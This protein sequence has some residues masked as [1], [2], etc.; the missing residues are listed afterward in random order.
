VP[1]SAPE[2]A[3]EPAAEPASDEPAAT[4]SAVTPEE[5]ESEA[6]YSARLAKAMADLRKKDLALRE[7][8]QGVAS[9]R[10][11]RDAIQAELAQIKE[12]LKDPFKALK[13]AGTTYEDLTRKYLKKE[14]VPPDDRDEIR[15]HVDE[16]ASALEQK[17]AEMQ[18]KLDAAEAERAERE[19]VVKQQQ[20]REQHLE[21]VSTVISSSADKFPL[22]AALKDGPQRLLNVCYANEANDPMQ[23]A[24][25][26]EKAIR[27]DL[28]ALMSAP[29]ALAALT[30]GQPKLREQLLAALGASQESSRRTAQPDEGPRALASDMVSAPS[31]P[32]TRPLKRS[33]AEKKQ[34][35]M[36]RLQRQ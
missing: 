5:Q 29:K 21:V 27:D 1:V 13:L 30:K 11:E 14:V 4:E 10:K 25:A 28:M 18:A 26:L 24:P 23:V 15:T 22:L 7:K 6:R 2:P 3:A 32:Q 36:L 17:L 33:M 9:V 16:K 20:V 35:A 31:N 19:A 8:D 12:A 34:A